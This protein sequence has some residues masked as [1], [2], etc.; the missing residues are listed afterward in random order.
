M[1]S[2][3]PDAGSP[4]LQRKLGPIQVQLIAIGGVIGSSYFLGLGELISRLGPSVVLAFML[5]GVIVWLVGRG[6]GELCAENP[7]DGSF[8]SY[9]NETVGP[10]WAAG[11]G[12]SYW[13]DWCAYIAS[14]MIG[15]GIIMHKFVP[16]IPAFAWT[17]LLASLVTLMNLLDVR[18]F[19]AIDSALALV[20]IAAAAAFAF[21]GIA[22]LFG[23]MGH[24]G[25]PVGLSLL[26]PHREVADLFPAGGAAVLLSMVLILVNFAG[27]EIIALASAETEDPAKHI[28]A[29]CRRVAI[30]IV[31]LFVLPLLVLVSIYPYNH[32]TLD[33]SVFSSALASHGFRWAAAFFSFIA[34]TAGF[35]CANS[36]LYG[37]V[38]AMYGLGKEGL[39]PAAVT[40]LNKHSVPAVATFITVCGCWAFFPLYVFFKGTSFYT[41][42]MA[43]SG[44]CGGVCW[45]SISWSHLRFRKA[46]DGKAPAWA[47]FAVW[48][49]FFI[50]MLIP[51]SAEFRGCLLIGIPALVIPML[52]ARWRGPKT[53]PNT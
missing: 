25:G 31:A 24:G 27:T 33:E 18:W 23:I 7:R 4:Q 8:V 6:M 44:F 28:A 43:V 40:K 5:G 37:T 47:Y 10:A 3:V 20:K 29:D 15:G 12:W 21:V 51:F 17:A 16:G 39:A 2:A 48:L 36:G 34:L 46:R 11:V 53:L 38:R 32:G 1:A 52:I 19:A 42:L 13:F 45:L 9:A 30:S 50:L 35:S 22:I 14:E 26:L 41:W 49:Q